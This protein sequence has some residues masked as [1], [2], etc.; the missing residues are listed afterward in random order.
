MTR[1]CIDFQTDLF[2]TKIWN[3]DGLLRYKRYNHGILYLLYQRQ[4]HLSS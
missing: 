3:S 4:L 1:I 2:L